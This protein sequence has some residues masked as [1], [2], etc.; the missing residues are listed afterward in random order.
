MFIYMFIYF[1]RGQCS[2]L[3][4]SSLMEVERR[5]GPR[6]DEGSQILS[7]C[8][9]FVFSFLSRRLHSFIHHSF[10]TLALALTARTTELDGFDLLWLD[11]P[12][13]WRCTYISYNCEDFV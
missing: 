3:V 11:T 5:R 4:E 6:R 1:G 9:L 8:T 13:H 10:L 7:A 12:S 2:T